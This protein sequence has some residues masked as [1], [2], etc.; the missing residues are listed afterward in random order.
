[1]IQFF[2]FLQKKKEKSEYIFLGNLT[3]HNRILKRGSFPVDTTLGT[4]YDNCSDAFRQEKQ[5]ISFGQIGH[6]INWMGQRISGKYVNTK[7]SRGELRKVLDKIQ[8]TIVFISSIE[9]HNSS[10]FL[11]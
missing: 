1:M 6:K 8:W 4:S 2:T 9:Q 10:L 11:F 7:F 5:N 3:V